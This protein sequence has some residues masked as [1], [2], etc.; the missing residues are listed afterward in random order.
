MLDAA[1]RVFS[2]RGYHAAGVDEIAEA[3]GISKPMVYAYLGSKEEL[4]VACLRREGARLLEAVA[5]VATFDD[6]PPERQLRAGL[7]AFFEFVAAHREAWSVLYRQGR[8]QEPFAGVITGMRGQWIEIVAGLLRPGSIVAPDV[9]PAAYAIVGAAE[10]LADW[11]V[12][13]GAG[14]GTG[15]PAALAARLSEMVW[16]GV[17]GRPAAAEPPR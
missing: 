15:D 4:F 2:R 3:A 1:V 16:H 9:V 11:I 5:A 14:E 8:A 12:D 13:H 7:R 10:S 17:D 6:P